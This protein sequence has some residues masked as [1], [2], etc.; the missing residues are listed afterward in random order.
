[1]TVIIISLAALAL[2][3]LVAALASRWDKT[4]PEEEPDLRPA[5]RKT[6]VATTGAMAG[7]GR[8]KKKFFG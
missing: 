1:M 3:G 7:L 5:D 6:V 4:Q 8:K 2:V